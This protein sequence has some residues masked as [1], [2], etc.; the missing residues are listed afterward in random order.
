ML[1]ATVKEDDGAEFRQDEV[2]FAGEGLVFRAVDR[3]PVAE[4]VEH[5]S[6]LFELRRTSRA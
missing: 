2:G 4:A 5:P 3:E 6:S 1:E